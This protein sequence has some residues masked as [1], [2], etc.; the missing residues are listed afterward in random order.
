MIFLARLRANNKKK[1]IMLADFVFLTLLV[2][3][4]LGLLIN[5]VEDDK[6]QKRVELLYGRR[7]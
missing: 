1:S 7:T 3:F 5:K 2:P 6:I 4:L